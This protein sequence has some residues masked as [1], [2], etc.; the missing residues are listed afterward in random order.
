MSIAA[1]APP[2]IAQEGADNVVNTARI[3]MIAMTADN[4]PQVKP[5]FAADCRFAHVLMAKMAR[6]EFIEARG[7]DER[8]A[9]RADF[10]A[11]V[12]GLVLYREAKRK[13]VDPMKVKGPYIRKASRVGIGSRAKVS[14]GSINLMEK[15]IKK[16][17]KKIK[18]EAGDA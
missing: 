13:E 1:L 14:N 7:N 18:A 3:K 4:V 12:W 6:D 16:C 17:R 11:D 9:Q 15:Q 2:A 8:V 10:Y 5:R